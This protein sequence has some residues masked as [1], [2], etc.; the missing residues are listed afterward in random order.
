[1]LYL[2][3][4]LPA[5]ILSMYAQFKVKST[6]RRYSNV[7]A[8]SG[9]TGRDVAVNLLNRN[10]IGRVHVEPIA[11]NLTDHYD[12]QSYTVRLS[13]AV[14]GNDSIAAIGVAAHE[15]GHA[16][17]HGQQYGPLELRHKLVPVTNFA[18]SAS[19]PIL[20]IGLLLQQANLILVGI[21]LF[22]AVVLF[23]LVTLPVEFNASRRAVAQLSDIGVIGNDEVPMVKKVLGAAAL[24]Y[25]A[26]A[27]SAIANL[28]YY[29]L[30]FM[31]SADD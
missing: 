29:L 22:S 15:V 25:L 8:S 5:L 17:Q 19:F 20:L 1:M 16:I 21:V 31:G 4:I 13:E 26:A 12:P 23:H 14:Y 28:L 7:R 11:G 2:M 27:L 18:S 30:I 9:A 10:G 6:F 3:L 24:T